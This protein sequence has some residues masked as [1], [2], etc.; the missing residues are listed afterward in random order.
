MMVLGKVEDLIKVFVYG[1]L[2]RGYGNHR[3]LQG[4]SMYVQDDCIDGNLFDLQY[5]P[6]A[7]PGDGVIHGEV[8]MVGPNTLAALDRL[9]GHPVYYQRRTVRTKFGGHEAWVYFMEKL[10]Q[11]ATPLPEGIWPAKAA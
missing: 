10:P 6:C 7:Q 1:T 8:Y 3:L 11:H 9:E 5:Y 4:R 2:K